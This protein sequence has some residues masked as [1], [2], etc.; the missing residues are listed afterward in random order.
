MWKWLLKILGKGKKKE[1]QTWPWPWEMR[2]CDNCASTDLSDSDDGMLMCGQCF[3][4][5]EK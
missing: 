1:L 4:D 5:M 3:H 2:F